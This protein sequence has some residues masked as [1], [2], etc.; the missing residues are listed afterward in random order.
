MAH[1]DDNLVLGKSTS[2]CMGSWIFIAD[3]SGGFRSR[4]IDQ[5]TLEALEAA[6]R[7]EINDFVDQ[8]EEVELSILNNGTR[9][10]PEFDAIRPKTLSEMEED[11]D[12]LLENIKQETPIDGKIL[13]SGCQQDIIQEEQPVNSISATTIENY[14]MDQ[15]EI[16]RP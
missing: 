14:L 7:Q 11:L 9:N 8:L 13:S 16:R 6:R 12:K 10:Q 4:P 1:L 3:G 15:M 2:F 5:N